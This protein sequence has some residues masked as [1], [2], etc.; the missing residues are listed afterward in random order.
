M[1]NI[2]VEFLG[3]RIGDPSVVRE[4]QVM[5]F[6]PTLRTHVREKFFEHEREIARAFAHRM[7]V[8]ED[9]LAAHVLAGAVNV[10]VWSAVNSW[11]AAGAAPDR[12]LPTLEEAFAV[13]GVATSATTARRRDSL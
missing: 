8:D 6:V 9:D 1:R 4:F 2:F 7:G 5:L 3:G 10:A 11:V 12:L 13:L